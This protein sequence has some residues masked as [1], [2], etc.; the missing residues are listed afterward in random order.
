MGGDAS[1]VS[2]AI[3][4]VSLTWIGYNSI[5][6]YVNPACITRNFTYA[7]WLLRDFSDKFED[8][9]FDDGPN[10]FL[11]WPCSYYAGFY[12]AISHN[13]ISIALEQDW[14]DGKQ[15]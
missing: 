14:A 15:A 2:S 6:E 3:T 9:R 1:S 11:I 7:C 12:N 4:P 10:I 5:E 13:N 8:V